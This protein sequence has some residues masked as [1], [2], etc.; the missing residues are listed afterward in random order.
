MCWLQTDWV[1]CNPVIQ[2]QCSATRSESEG[3]LATV[4]NDPLK[5]WKWWWLMIDITIEWEYSEEIH[6]GTVLEACYRWG[7]LPS[8]WWSKRL[9]NWKITML[10]MGKLTISM[11]MFNSCVSLPEGSYAQNLIQSSHRL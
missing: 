4:K 8:S 1:C 2:L 10:S 6:G 9:H 11:T 7:P 3:G 5:I